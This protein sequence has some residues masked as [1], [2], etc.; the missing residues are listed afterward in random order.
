MLPH[1]I[2]LEVTDDRNQG[3]SVISTVSVKGNSRSLAGGEVGGAG[4][5]T[6]LGSFTYTPRRIL[7]AAFS[8]RN[9]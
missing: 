5:G 1:Q 4:A 9:S 8:D 6:G 7:L 2:S 3:D